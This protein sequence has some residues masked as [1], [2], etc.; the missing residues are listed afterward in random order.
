[1]LMPSA[2]AHS[3]LP[4]PLPLTLRLLHSQRLG[5]KESAEIA[6]R[7]DEAGL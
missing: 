5:V 4:L 7:F 2:T 3:L 6:P 1:M